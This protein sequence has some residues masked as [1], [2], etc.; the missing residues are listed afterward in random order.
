MGGALEAR[1]A[2]Q[3]QASFKAGC[4]HGDTPSGAFFAQTIGH[5]DTGIVKE[6]LG[7]CLLAI[8]LFDRP[9]GDA[10]CVHRDEDKGQPFMAT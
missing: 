5:G 4:R 8:D 6:D 3:H 1:R 2:S 9:N 10:G 7:K